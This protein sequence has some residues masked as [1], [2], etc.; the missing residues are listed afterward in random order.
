MTKRFIYKTKAI[1][2]DTIHAWRTEHEQT[3]KGVAP[4]AVWTYDNDRGGNARWK[5]TVDEQEAPLAHLTLWSMDDMASQTVE[6]EVLK[7][8]FS[9]RAPV[10]ATP[11]W[12]VHNETGPAFI[13]R[14]PPI[15]PM[16]AHH[17]LRERFF[18]FNVEM[19][20]DDLDD[21]V[22]AI[23]EGE[24]ESLKFID[25]RDRYYGQGVVDYLRG[26]EPI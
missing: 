11:Y 26:G 23:A 8:G 13:L 19:M 7:S 12:M 2:F 16:R 9:R 14:D 6:T 25:W 3:L 1:P 21:G 24:N 4:S 20:P 15:A 5:I 18:L 10:A 22:R 17:A